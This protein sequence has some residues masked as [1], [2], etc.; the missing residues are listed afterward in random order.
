LNYIRKKITKVKLT[1]IFKLSY[2]TVFDC[3]KRYKESNGYIS[4]QHIHAGCKPRFT[5]KKSTLAFL[6]NYPVRQGIDIRDHV[7]S[8]IP[9]STYMIIDREWVLHMK[10]AKM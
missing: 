10:R 4:K 9:F 7:S 1:K 8:V 3:I 5:D 6:K 2:Q